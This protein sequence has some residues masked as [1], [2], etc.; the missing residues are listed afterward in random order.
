LHGGSGVEGDALSPET[1]ET[2]KATLRMGGF[3]FAILLEDYHEN[4]SRAVRPCLRG[5]I[6]VPPVAHNLR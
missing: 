1:L 5:R 3:A 2:T 4:K 6:T